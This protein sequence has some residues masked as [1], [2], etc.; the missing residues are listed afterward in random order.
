MNT[1]IDG[2][3]GINTI[4]REKRREK[5]GK[6]DLGEGLEPVLGVLEG[7]DAGR[8]PQNYNDQRVQKIS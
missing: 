7:V 8:V 1:M 6:R 2:I 3:F 4:K 5:G